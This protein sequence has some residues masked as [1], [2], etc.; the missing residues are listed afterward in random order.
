ML[1]NLSAAADRSVPGLGYAPRVRDE[2]ERLRAIGL[3]LIT[4]EENPLVRAECIR[5]A[6]RIHLSRNKVIGFVPA[7]DDIAVPPVIIQI[8][9][10]LTELTG[11]T[12]A[13]VDANVRWPGLAGLARPDDV[14]DDVDDD[15]E[16]DDGDG[17]GASPARR[18]AST[19]TDRD[20]SV[21]RTRWVR[22]SLAL[23][24]PP[25]SER[26]GEAVPQ[27]AD[28]LLHGTELFAHVLVD[29]AGFD[30]LGE[31]AAGAA[32]MDAAI[33]LARI[34]KTLERDLFLMEKAMPTNRFMGVL[35]VG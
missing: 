26:A 28:L 16:D 8:G 10:A 1:V 22:G 3:H 6:R 14:D 19:L 4:D 9:I 20:G 11:S 21:F 32:C 12:I 25:H 30:L 17:Y 15:V 13:V 31:H 2:D 24:T 35:L 27:L 18:R 5:I 33:V 7:T 29:L 34:G 23:L